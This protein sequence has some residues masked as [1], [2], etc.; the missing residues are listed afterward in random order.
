MQYRCKLKAKEKPESAGK[1]REICP[2]QQQ[3]GRCPF[4]K[5]PFRSRVWR[6]PHLINHAH[7]LHLE[8]GDFC[9][10][11]CILAPAHLSAISKHTYICVDRDAENDSASKKNSKYV[12]GRSQFQVDV[13]SGYY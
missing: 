3:T 5:S 10:L 8:A 9:C 2:P 12:Q 1:G 6:A 4:F 11:L 7:L 13:V